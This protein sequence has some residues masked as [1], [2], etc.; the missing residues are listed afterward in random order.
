MLAA[1]ADIAK[2]VPGTEGGRATT[3]LDTLLVIAHRES[4]EFVRD[5]Q[6]AQLERKPAP[7]GVPV[8]YSFRREVELKPGSHQAKLI[9]RDAA[10]KVLGSVILEIDVPPLAALRV[11]TPVLASGL[12]ATADGS[13]APVLRVERAFAPGSQLYCS[14]DVYGAEEGTGRPAP[15]EGG[16]RAA[17]AGRPRPRQHDAQRDPAH[18]DRRPQPAHPDPARGP[19]G[20]RLRARGHGE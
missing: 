7:P 2:L 3:T 5:D 13:L 12:A 16:T 19:S 4:A 1:E 9:V 14:F 10:S 17:P 11:S 20:R 18:L 6:Q 15:R 8:W